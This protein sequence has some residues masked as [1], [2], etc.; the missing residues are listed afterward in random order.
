MVSKR[1]YGH[2]LRSYEQFK[3]FEKFKIG[4]TSVNLKK[5]GYISVFLGLNRIYFSKFQ[6][7]L[8]YQCIL[9]PKP[10]KSLNPRLRLA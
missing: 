3:V 1:L 9:E 7:Q 5:C 4:F 8:I 2:Y 10:A 6:N